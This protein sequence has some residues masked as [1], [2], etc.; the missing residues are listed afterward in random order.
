MSV[1]PPPKTEEEV[2][3]FGDLNDDIKVLLKSSLVG[4]LAIGGDLNTGKFGELRRDLFLR[5][6]SSYD[7]S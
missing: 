2:R 4:V 3:C 1:E 5:G 7:F 6:L